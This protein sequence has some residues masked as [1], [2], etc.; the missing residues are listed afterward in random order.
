MDQRLLEQL[1]KAS[2][3]KAFV[4]ETTVEW[5]REIP[6]DCFVVPET[7]VSIYGLD[8]Y[9]ALDQVQRAL[10]IRHEVACL[11]SFA[12]RLE[13][14]LMHRFAEM[15]R[16]ADP[17]EAWV[18]YFLHELEEE[19]RHSRMF[20]RTIARMETGGYRMDG[21]LGFFEDKL[22]WLTRSPAFFLL[23]TL[24]AEEIPDVLFQKVMADQ[25]SHPILYQVSRI[26]RIEEARHIKF[27]RELFAELYAKC[28][29]VERSVLRALAPVL[30][31][32]IFD[33][34]VRPSA[35]LRAGVVE[36][37]LG[38]WRLWLRARESE[39]RRA[40]RLQCAD[41]LAGFLGDV[42]VIDQSNRA[43]W[44]SRGLIAG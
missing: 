25:T 9:R 15:I 28:G 34:S 39:H 27:G 42:G 29:L 41:R 7:L 40:L 30:V 3:H 11:L 22:A 26:H 31:A 24:A 32:A 23:L 21:V 20:A 44:I 16:S 37:R 35:Y 38:A 36:G 14:V 12:I 19:A 13:S 10:L 1:C 33:A 6:R 5:E 4:P 18:P 8:V 43:R 2:V 17:L